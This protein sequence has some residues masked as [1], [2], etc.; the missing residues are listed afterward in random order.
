V[1]KILKNKIGNITYYKI[2]ECGHL[3]NIEKSDEVN[4][5]AEEFMSNQFIEK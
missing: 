3:P 1:A 5:M 2:D 4:K